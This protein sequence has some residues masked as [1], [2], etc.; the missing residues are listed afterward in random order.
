MNSRERILKSIQHEEPDRVPFDMAGTTVTAITKNAYLNAFAYPNGMIY[1]H[2]GLLARMDSEDQLAAVLA[3]ELTHCTQRHAL[4][5]FR[6]CKDQPAILTAVQHTLLKTKGLEDMARYLGV[7]TPCI[8]RL[9]SPGKRPKLTV[10][11]I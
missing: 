5:A 3:H 10:H 9:V 6:M 11:I 7:T 4:K 1:I 8:Y 2:T